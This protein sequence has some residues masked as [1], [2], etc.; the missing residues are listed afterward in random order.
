MEHGPFTSMI[1]LWKDGKAP[2]I[3]SCQGAALEPKLGVLLSPRGVWG[4]APN[5][6]STFCMEKGP[7]LKSSGDVYI[8]IMW[9]VYIYNYIY[10]ILYHIRLYHIILHIKLKDMILYDTRWH[11]MMVYNIVWYCMILYWTIWD[12]MELHDNFI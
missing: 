12:Y 6:F 10:M 2:L 1:Y 3:L 9:N 5:N 8:Y 4:I 7:D 11:Y